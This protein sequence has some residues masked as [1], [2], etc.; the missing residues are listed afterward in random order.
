MAF[1]TIGQIIRGLATRKFLSNYAPIRHRFI[2]GLNGFGSLINLLIPLRFGDVLRLILL[3]RKRLGTV[4]STY[5]VVVERVADLFIAN[6]VFFALAHFREDLSI[7]TINSIG[8]AFG[9][10]GLLLF[11]FGTRHSRFSCNAKLLGSFDNFRLVFPR[12]ELVLFCLSIAGCWGFTSIAFLF[13]GKRYGGLIQDWISLNSNF[14]DPLSLALSVYNL[15]FLTLLIPLVLAYLYSLSIPSPYRLSLITTREFLGSERSIVEIKPFDSKFAGSGSDLF[16]A[17]IVHSGTKQFTTYMV[18]VDYSRGHEIAATNFM[19]VAAPQFKF[20]LVHYTKVFRNAHCVI[21]E[22]I[23][24]N[25]SNEPS[26][27][28]FEEMLSESD[29]LDIL[30]NVI[31]HILDFHSDER[32]SI[33]ATIDEGLIN[34][35]KNRILRSEVFVALTLNYLNHED[36]IRIARF[37]K[38]TRKVIEE[39]DRLK[40]RFSQGPCHGDASLSNFLVQKVGD[41]R[42]IRSIDPNTRFPISNVE[43][44]LAKV[45][46]STHALYEF[47]LEDSNAFP[48]NKTDFLRIQQELGWASH[49]IESIS[50]VN[51][52]NYL[53]LE[54]LR[55]FL[56]LHLI[57]IVPYKVNSGRESLRQFLDLVDWVDELVNF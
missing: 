10:F 51:T 20:P 38:L 3:S 56:F 8:W 36:R 22:Y 44:D 4:I 13:L 9:T 5:F 14:S 27:N 40:S 35:I 47:C 17:K 30:N 41:I 50:D 46:Q 25:D 45:M 53:D 49:L 33:E 26:Q 11:L 34:E 2:F 57:R 6:T 18:R 12:R 1:L 31:D 21:L 39:A 37:T 16:L 52:L 32:E 43:F 48:R 24:D 29:S 23:V 55:F 54:L 19:K 42:N 28:A 7:S 15:L